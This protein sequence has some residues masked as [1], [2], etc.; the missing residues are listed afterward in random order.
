MISELVLLIR[1]I[2]HAIILKVQFHV[3]IISTIILLY[4]K[5]SWISWLSMN[6]LNIQGNMHIFSILD[7]SLVSSVQR[8]CKIILFLQ[9]KELIFSDFH[10]LKSK[11]HD[12]INHSRD[13]AISWCFKR[14]F[15]WIFRFWSAL[16]EL[17]SY[18][19]IHQVFWVIST[20][21]SRNSSQKFV[22]FIISSKKTAFSLIISLKN[23]ILTL[24]I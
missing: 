1:Y 19:Q 4:K 15:L 18:P 24:F 17:G 21:L 22:F 5:W 13:M 14:L 9:C 6:S 7:Q 11:D 2:T 8:I 3:L 23:S 20:P 12:I 16:M 10:L